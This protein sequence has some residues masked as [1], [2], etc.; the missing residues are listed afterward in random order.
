VRVAVGHL[1][2]EFGVRGRFAGGEERTLVLVEAAR[3]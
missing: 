2:H 3:R 1:A